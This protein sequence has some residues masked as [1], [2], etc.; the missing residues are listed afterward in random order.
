MRTAGVP[1]TGGVHREPSPRVY[2][3]R[4]DKLQSPYDYYYYY[5]NN[6]IDPHSS[7]Y[8]NYTVN[9]DTRSVKFRVTEVTFV[10]KTTWRP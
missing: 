1:K 2:N 9:D 3:N 10:D 5:Y 8:D 7:R 4:G 6:D